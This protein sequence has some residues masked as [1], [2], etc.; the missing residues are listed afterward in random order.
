MSVTMMRPTTTR[1]PLL[2]AAA[3]V[4]ALGA[5]LYLS[6]IWPGMGAQLVHEPVSQP[7]GA[8]SSADVEIGMGVGQLRIGALAQPSDLIAGEIAY[9]DRNSVTRE[10]ALRGNT[11]T[12][13]LHE[14]DSQRNSLIK[15]RNDDAVWD[16]QLSPA[17]PMRLTIEAGVGESRLD[18]AQLKLTDLDLQTGVGNTILTLPREGHVQAHV[19]GGVGNTIIRVPA[20][21]AVRLTLDAGVGTV[22]VPANYWRQGDV[23]VSPDYD[24]AANRVDLT[25][26]SGV[27]NITI[28]QISNS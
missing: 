28:Q 11:A 25:V 16:L 19:E 12:F 15:Y 9:S 8:A 27:G 22:S 24:A 13:K 10:F 4:V 26:S 17:T 7:L 18:L 2:I 1:R 6:G 23:A 5:G 14:Q 21:V 20:G 3:I